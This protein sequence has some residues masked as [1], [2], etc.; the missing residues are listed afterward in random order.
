MSEVKRN[1]RK[2]IGT[3]GDCD[4]LEHGGGLV[5]QNSDNSVD[6]VC[7]EEIPETEKGRRWWV[8]RTSIGK[9]DLDWID[10]EGIALLCGL[11]IE[12]VKRLLESDDVFDLVEAYRLAGLYHGWQEL[13]TY[14]SKLSKTE[15]NKH[16]GRWMR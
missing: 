1:K 4:P 11:E 6:L 5:F 7:F 14:Y 8:Y 9:G 16:W 10:T 12:E 15:I 3:F 2:L 13:D